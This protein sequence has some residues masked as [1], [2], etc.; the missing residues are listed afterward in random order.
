MSRL[1]A[2]SQLTGDVLDLGEETSDLTELTN[3]GETMATNR[4]NSLIVFVDGLQKWE[5]DDE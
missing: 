2:Y 1:R 4:D 5:T 3:L